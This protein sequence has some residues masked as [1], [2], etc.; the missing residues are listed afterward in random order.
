MAQVYIKD[1]QANLFYTYDW[2]KWLGVSET[3]TTST[4]TVPSGLTKTNESSTTTTA[5]V[6][7]SGG[8]VGQNYR[9]TNHIVTSIG[10]VDERSFQIH[11]E[12]R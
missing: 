7:I 3:I 9:V 10:Q 1:P 2:S 6:Q 4:W 12:E 5:K 11:C 8:T